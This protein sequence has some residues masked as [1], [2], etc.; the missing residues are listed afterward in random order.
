[1]NFC[2]MYLFQ[3]AIC[4]YLITY[5]FGFFRHEWNALRLCIA[6]INFLLAFI[7]NSIID[8]IFV[9]FAFFEGSAIIK[10]KIG[11]TYI[12]SN[13]HLQMT[14]MWFNSCYPFVLWWKVDTFGFYLILN[15][16][17]QIHLIKTVT[18]FPE[19]FC[20]TLKKSFSTSTVIPFV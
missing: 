2:F 12:S 6:S 18:L 19:L 3:R 20:Q 9:I 8:S 4:K 10:K 5:L 1:M 14:S 15:C 11:R 16:F 17:H 13:F 7:A